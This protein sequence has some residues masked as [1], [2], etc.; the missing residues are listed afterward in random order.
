VITTETT[1]SIHVFP[2]IA[3]VASV[4]EGGLLFLEVKDTEGYGFPIT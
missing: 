3:P 1:I 2:N 4:I